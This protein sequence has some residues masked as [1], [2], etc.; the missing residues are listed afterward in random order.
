M[1]SAQRDDAPTLMSGEVVDD[2]GVAPIRAANE[3]PAQPPTLPRLGLAPPPQRTRAS[4]WSGQCERLP[5]P[6]RV[7]AETKGTSRVA[8]LPRQR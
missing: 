6:L 3:L 4:L 2:E 1:S 7:E 8:R 5:G